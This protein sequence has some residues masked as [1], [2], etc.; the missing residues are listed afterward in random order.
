MQ[1]RSTQVLGGN[2]KFCDISAKLSDEDG[3]R[4]LTSP[5]ESEE[6]RAAIAVVERGE[7]CKSLK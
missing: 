4:T 6:S 3:K 5:L 1:S 7:V 2:V